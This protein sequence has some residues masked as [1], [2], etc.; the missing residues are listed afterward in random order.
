MKG[1][2]N[3]DLIIYD[4]IEMGLKTRVDN[5]FVKLAAFHEK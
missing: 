5:G 3:P 4:Y 1:F 2:L